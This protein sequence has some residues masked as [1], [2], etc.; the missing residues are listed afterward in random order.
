LVTLRLLDRWLEEGPSAAASGGWAAR[1]VEG[2]IDQMDE[3]SPIPSILRS[4]LAAMQEAHPADLHGVLPRLLAYGQAL[5][6]DAKWTLAMDVYETVIAHAHPTDESD[7]AI[8]AHLRKA[9]CLRTLGSFADALAVYATAEAVASRAGDMLNVLRARIGDAK[10]AIAR[11]NLPRAEAVLD[12]TISQASQLGIHTIRALALQDRAMVAGLRG[13]HDIAVELAYQAMREAP[14]P[15]NRDRILSDIGTAFQRLGLRSVARDAFLVLSAT[16]QE[17]YMRWVATLSLMGIAAEDG[18]EP[19]FEQYR[20]QLR[21]T[22]M[23][24]QL[25]TEYYIYLGRAYRHLERE[26][27]GQIALAKAVQL[28]EHYGFFALLFEAEDELRS[29]MPLRQTAGEVSPEVSEIASEVRQMRDAAL[30]DI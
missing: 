15:V 28:A 12:E 19:L 8:S 22:E 18:S 13:R 11:G 16:A 20:A 21:P 5:E 2:A 9:F 29:A 23:P 24:P 10:V 26:D 30:A 25:E 14:S 27:L 3:G 17:Q 1:A 6:Y 4:V 7:A